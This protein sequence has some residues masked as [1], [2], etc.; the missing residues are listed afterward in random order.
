MHPSLTKVTFTSLP[1]RQVVPQDTATS[2]TLL[3]R[4]PLNKDARPLC[5]VC[6]VPAIRVGY[7]QTRPGFWSCCAR[8][9]AASSCR[10]QG[11]HRTHLGACLPY[12]KDKWGEL[13][14]DNRW[15]EATTTKYAP[16]PTEYHNGRS[17]VR[18]D[19]I[20]VCCHRW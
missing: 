3:S 1:P 18:K 5:L 6:F 2:R 11:I 9:E 4:H 12:K 20:L 19:G 15:I 16:T 14:I 10:Q 17:R 13:R 8:R 7:D